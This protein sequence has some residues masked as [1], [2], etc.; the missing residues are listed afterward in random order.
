MTRRR[1]SQASSRARSR[2][3]TGESVSGYPLAVLTRIPL[4]KRGGDEKNRSKTLSSITRRMKPARGPPRRRPHRKSSAHSQASSRSFGASSRTPMPPFHTT[5]SPPHQGRRTCR[6][7]R[8]RPS[9][10]PTTASAQPGAERMQ[11]RGRG[12]PGSGGELTAAETRI[13]S[14]RASWATSRTMRRSCPRRTRSRR[15]STR[16]SPLSSR[17]S[18]SSTRRASGAAWTTTSSGPS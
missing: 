8:P 7:P 17:G 3:S 12:G 15:S 16:T 5:T 14:W 11:P 4:T 1:V 6:P 2:R 18:P 9:R 13:S 10:R